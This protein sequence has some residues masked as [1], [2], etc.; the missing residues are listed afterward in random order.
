MTPTFS[1]RQELAK[2]F[3]DK[4]PRMR[5]CLKPQAGMFRMTTSFGHRLNIPKTSVRAGWCRWTM[6]QRCWKYCSSIFRQVSIL[7][8]SCGARP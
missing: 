4:V 3:A 1:E 7:E 6:I 8:L 5:R 2:Q